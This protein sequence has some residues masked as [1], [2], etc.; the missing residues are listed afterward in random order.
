MIYLVQ[1]DTKPLDVTLNVDAA[2]TDATVTFAM[3][4]RS[5]EKA[6]S[7]DC[8]ILDAAAKQVRFTW[9]AGGTDTPGVYDAEWQITYPGTGGVETAPNS[10]TEIIYIR[11]DIA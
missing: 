8:T 4:Q 3:R 1:D 10:E 9:P 7:G 11:A 6:V 5:G 2:L